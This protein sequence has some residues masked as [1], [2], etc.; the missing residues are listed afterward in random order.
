MKEL[1]NIQSV[2]D[3]KVI[4]CCILQNFKHRLEIFW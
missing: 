3:K 2:R 1:L 4:P